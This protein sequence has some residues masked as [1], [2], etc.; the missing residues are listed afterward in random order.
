MVLPSGICV[1]VVSVGTAIAGLAILVICSLLLLILAGKI[2]KMMSLYKG[3]AVNI[4]KALKMLV[5]K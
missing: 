5:S 4:G 2:Y 1:G 3:N